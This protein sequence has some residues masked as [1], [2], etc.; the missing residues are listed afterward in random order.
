MTTQNRMNA[1]F[2]FKDSCWLVSSY[3]MG[4][5]P[6]KWKPSKPLFFFAHEPLEKEWD[7]W[8]DEI[9]LWVELLERKLKPKGHC[10]TVPSTSTISWQQL[11]IPFALLP[12]WP[13]SFSLFFYTK[14]S[15]LHL[16]S[17]SL[18]RHIIPANLP[19]LHLRSSINNLII[20]QGT[21]KKQVNG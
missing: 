6:L 1:A 16:F 2:C 7:K 17:I 10:S 11:L 5:V 3:P 4:L 20:A 18:N 13:F 19:N 12:F 15:L 21:L 14:Y 9:R 8:D